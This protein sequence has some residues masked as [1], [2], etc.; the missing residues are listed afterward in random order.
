MVHKRSAEVGR[1]RCACLRIGEGG[2]IVIPWW[3][4]L[5]ALGAQAAWWNK[6]AP[7]VLAGYLNGDSAP[8]RMHGVTED[9]TAYA[10]RTWPMERD[11]KPGVHFE[12]LKSGEPFEDGHA[13]TQQA[14]SE[15]VLSRL[16]ELG[17]APDPVT[18]H[19]TEDEA[20]C[21]AC[22]QGKSCEDACGGEG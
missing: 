19:A 3:V 16:S 22:A 6:K 18:R 13:D 1:H 21:D 14:A 7:D 11:G 17:V 12:I 10:W 5:G 15:L 8:D 4:F 20:C 9:G 2:A